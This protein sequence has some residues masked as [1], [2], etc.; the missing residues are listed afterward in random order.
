[1]IPDNKPFHTAMKELADA[2]DEDKVGVAIVAFT[3][4][5]DT[6]MMFYAKDDHLL[7]LMGLSVLVQKAITNL[8]SMPEVSVTK[9]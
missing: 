8:P 9:K 4:D 2:L 7:S 6:R 3:S 5:K 1:M